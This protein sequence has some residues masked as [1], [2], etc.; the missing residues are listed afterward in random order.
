MRE[1]NHLTQIHQGPQVSY[2]F[3]QYYAASPLGYQP[4]AVVGSQNEVIVEGLAPGQIPGG[5]PG[6][7]PGGMHGLLLPIQSQF[8]PVQGV[9]GQ[10]QQQHRRRTKQT[11]KQKAKAG[12]ST[13]KKTVKKVA[14]LA[15]KMSK[16]KKKIKLTKSGRKKKEKDPDAPKRGR[17]AFNFFLDEFRQEYRTSNPAAKGVVEVTKA[18]SA[19]WKS[20]DPAKRKVHEDKAEA[21]QREYALAKKKYV[22]DGGPVMFKYLNGP[23]RPPTAYF[24]FLA[25][26][27]KGY[28]A[29]HPGMRGVTEM[30]KEAGKTWKSMAAMEREVYTRKGKEVKEEYYKIKAMTREERAAYLKSDP[31]PYR[32]YLALD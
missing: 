2:G 21:S 5:L 25:N 27:R 24:I 19:A 29:E 7:L 15:K 26:F 23:H 32:K 28:I 1:L 22:E 30:S 16:P 6:G 13:K 31:D 18:A 3:P 12:P 20:L 11:A 17:T 8:K 10:P 14:K 4:Q 9:P